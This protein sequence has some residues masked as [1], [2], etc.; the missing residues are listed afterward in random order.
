MTRFV[1]GN[2]VALLR[3]GGEYFPALVGAIDRA[4]HEVWLETYIFA[5]DDAG[6]IVAAAL[7][8]AASRGVAVRVMV[9]GWGARHYLTRSLENTMVAGGVTLLKVRP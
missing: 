3:S 5:D 7:V 4:E 6:R 1:Q 9:D 8:R 2:R